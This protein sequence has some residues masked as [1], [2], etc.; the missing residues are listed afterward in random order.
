MANA[1]HTPDPDPKALQDTVAARFHRKDGVAVIGYCIDV[2]GRTTDFE[3]VEPFPGDPE[4]DEILIAT[5]VTWRFKPFLVEGRPMKTC[6]KKTWKLKFA[7]GPTQTVEHPDSGEP[8]APLPNSL[9]RDVCVHL[10][11]LLAAASTKPPTA[12]ELEPFVYACFDSLETERKQLDD[13]AFERTA[14][15]ILATTSFEALADC[16]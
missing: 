9:S 3:V 11:D 16:K 4:I 6:T 13:A 8:R 12:A 14:R 7:S 2:Q 5:M 10:G 15:C 1:I